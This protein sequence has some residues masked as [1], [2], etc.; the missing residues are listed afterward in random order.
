MAGWRPPHKL[1]SPPL[2]PKLSLLPNLVRSPSPILLFLISPLILYLLP[3]IPSHLSSPHPP[4]YHRSSFIS[5]SSPNLFVLFISFIFRY[6]HFPTFPSPS[7][8][9]VTVLNSLFLLFSTAVMLQRRT[10]T[11]S[12]LPLIATL[13]ASPP[14]PLY[15]P[16][17]V[18]P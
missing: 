10:F 1:P 14:K 18:H 17:H 5:T 16:C 7:L 12:P 2:A 4:F 3:Y 9:S 6:S 8:S 15:R 13:L 11:F